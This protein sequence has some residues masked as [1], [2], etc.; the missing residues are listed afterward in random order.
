MRHWR[1]RAAGFVVGLLLGGWLIAT[2]AAQSY[3]W[4]AI[5][6]IPF[7]PGLVLSGPILAADGSQAAPSYAFTNY[8]TTGLYT[9]SGGVAIATAGAVRLTV[10]SRGVV[11]TPAALSG[12]F[13]E[14]GLSLAQTWNTTGAPV[15]ADWT[16]TDTASDAA[17]LAFRIRGGASG[18][19]EMFKV[20][21]A[22]TGTFSG[23]INSG[24]NVFLGN[25]NGRLSSGS[26]GVITLS[27]SP[28]T[29]FTSLNLG[30][31]TGNSARGSSTWTNGLVTLDMATATG[32]GTGT[33]TSPTTAIPAN[34][35]VL[36][37]TCKVTTVLAGAGLTTFSIGDGTDADRWGTGIAI[38]AGT[39]VNLGAT[40]IASPVYYSSATS[41][42]L[43]AAA[44]VFSTGVLSCSPILVSATPI[45]S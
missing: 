25:G 8:P 22:G 24:S 34:S 35:L 16:I 36:G 17:S 28:G 27:D 26:N 21:K 13:S 3:V 20:S 18:T 12:S 1:G 14:S 31:T 30:P 9:N 5:N 2:P 11:L 23:S 33:I 38:A 32:T 10:N 29:F 19:T 45:G 43:T 37:M 7:G 4:G 44:G 39:T 40:T 6:G 41:I 42:V 15:F